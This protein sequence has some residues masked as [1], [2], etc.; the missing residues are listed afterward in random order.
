VRRDRCGLDRVEL[1]PPGQGTSRKWPHPALG[2]P[3]HPA[4]DWSDARLLRGL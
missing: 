4:G 3:P 2:I 1:C